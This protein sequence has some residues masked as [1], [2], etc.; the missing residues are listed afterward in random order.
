MT[1]RTWLRSAGESRNQLRRSLGLPSSRVLRRSSWAVLW[2]AACPLLVGCGSE[3]DAGPSDPGGEATGGAGG[4]RDDDAT[5]GAS[6]TMPGDGGVELPPLP[7]PDPDA[8]T[9]PCDER[10]RVGQWPDANGTVPAPDDD[11]NLG[12]FDPDAM[13]F[14]GS[15]QPGLCNGQA[16]WVYAPDELGIG[17]S[18]LMDDLVINPATRRAVY[19]SRLSKSVSQV[20]PDPDAPRGSRSVDLEL[21][22]GCD[23]LG[24]RVAPDGTYAF[25]CGETWKLADGTEIYAGEDTVY[26][27]PRLGSQ[28]IVH[29]GCRGYAF[30]GHGILEMH[31]GTMTELSPELQ[32]SFGADLVA[33]RAAADGFW[34]V[35]GSRLAHISFEGTATWLGKFPTI[36]DSDWLYALGTDGALYHRGFPSGTIMRTS[37]DGNSHTLYVE[38]EGVIQSTFLQPFTGP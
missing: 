29:L 32:E 36:Y 19:L 20:E 16:A 30:V 15:S 11:L 5:A 38:A 7:P 10:P 17:M 23:V 14:A 27:P 6:G 2:L 4:A 25:Q 26:D 35:V 9:E 13:Y 12:A 3:D 31:T 21:P 1:Y 28:T 24:F 22:E 34:T 33:T 37:L 8:R 18:C